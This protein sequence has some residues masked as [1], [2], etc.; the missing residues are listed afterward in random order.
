VLGAFLVLE[1]RREFAILRAVGADTA[2][3][4]VGPASEGVLVVLWSLLIGVPVGLGLA[5]LEV[6]VLSLFFALPPPLLTI[7]TGALA[8]FTVFMAVTSTIG[9]AAALAAVIR[10]RPATVLRE[11]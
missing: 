9:M 4:I 10:V 7:P 11:P 8:V 2:Q 3:V 1:R 5:L 6:R